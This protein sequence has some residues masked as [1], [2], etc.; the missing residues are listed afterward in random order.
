MHLMSR[1]VASRSKRPYCGESRRH[2][3][4]ATKAGR[5]SRKFSEQLFINDM[6]ESVYGFQEI[7][8]AENKEGEGTTHG[9]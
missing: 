4:D 8:N 5:Q 1:G 3:S 6:N 9:N 2:V 7:D